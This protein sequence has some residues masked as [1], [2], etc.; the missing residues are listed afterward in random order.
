[1]HTV[2]KC[3][4][5]QAPGEVQGSGQHVVQAMQTESKWPYRATLAPVTLPRVQNMA[6]M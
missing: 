2:D 6:P 5:A 1:M 4:K 3:A